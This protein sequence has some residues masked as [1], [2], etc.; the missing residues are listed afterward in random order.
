ML[1]DARGLPILP[2]AHR[3]ALAEQMKADDAAYPGY[4]KAYATVI[5]SAVQAGIMTAVVWLFPTPYPM[6]MFSELAPAEAW[7]RKTIAG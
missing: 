6:R 4:M 2:A 1:I 5:D 3:R 7:V